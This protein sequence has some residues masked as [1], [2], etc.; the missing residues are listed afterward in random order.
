LEGKR[1]AVF[2]KDQKEPV[3]RTLVQFDEL[4]LV[5]WDGSNLNRSKTLFLWGVVTAVQPAD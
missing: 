3:V 4:G 1:V 5:L 2:L